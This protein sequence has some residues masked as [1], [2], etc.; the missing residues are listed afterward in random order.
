MIFDDDLHF[1]PERG[2]KLFS[3]C[4]L[5]VFNGGF[6]VKTVKN[7]RFNS[8]MPVQ[9]CVL[10]EWRDAVKLKSFRV[11]QFRFE[12]S[13][14][15]VYLTPS[16]SSIFRR[17]NQCP[18]WLLYS[19]LFHIVIA[20]N[21][22]PN[23][24]KDPNPSYIYKRYFFPAIGFFDPKSNFLPCSKIDFVAITKSDLR[25]QKTTSRG[26][27]IPPRN[28]T[29][30]I[31]LKSRESLTKRLPWKLC[32]SCPTLQMYQGRFKQTRNLIKLFWFY[33]MH[34]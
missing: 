23:P 1:R 16:L 27:L 7:C 8:H 26:F 33:W 9:R 15:H 24:D 10:Y 31:R 25:L 12:C 34:R 20:R 11:S 28:W 29:E 18:I 22:D 32:C 3:V 2:A 4:R 5:G 13:F 19:W 17:E 21:S 14:S 6:S 30:L